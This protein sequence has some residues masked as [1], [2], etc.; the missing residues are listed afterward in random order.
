MKKEFRVFD[1]FTSNDNHKFSLYEGFRDWIKPDWR[2]M[3]I[4][5]SKLA[6]LKL[7]RGITNMVAQTEQ[8]LVENG[9]TLIGKNILEF[10]CNNGNNAYAMAYIEDTKIHGIDILEYGIHQTIDLNMNI[11]DKIKQQNYLD[12]QREYISKHIPRHI[13]DKVTF[14][15]NDIANFV[16]PEKYDVVVS[17]DTME[18][19]TQPKQAIDNIYKSLKQ[20]GFA[21]FHYNSFFSIT[22]GHSLCTLDFPYGH[23]IL[24]GN[25]FERYIKSHRKMECKVAM[26]FYNHNL[27]R[28]S[29][30][31]F[32]C[33]LK[34]SGFKIQLMEGH[35]P[36]EDDE[37]LWQEKIDSEIQPLVSRVYPNVT[38]DDL[39]NDVFFCI[40]VKD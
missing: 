19:I 2:D 33:Y 20:G 18:H 6:G 1:T 3:L 38:R 23:C 35:I 15:N 34:Q 37:K 27:N 30:S 5:R 8:R 10:G 7:T 32:I 16:E 11:I 9:F 14:S 40:A 25:D 36:F 29:L 21:Y 31:D 4:P 24:D 17:W 12:S 13:K 22:G 26:D 28:M 39:L